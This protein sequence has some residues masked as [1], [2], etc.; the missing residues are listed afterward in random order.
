MTD[1]GDFMRLPGL[2]RRWDM[3]MMLEPG[4]D[5]H[6]EYATTAADGTPLFAVYRRD[7]PAIRTQQ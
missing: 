6:V 2:Y 7:N 4:A 1:E 3:A 5:Y